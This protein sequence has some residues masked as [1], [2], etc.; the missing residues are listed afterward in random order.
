MILQKAMVHHSG[1]QLT[2]L[3]KRISLEAAQRPQPQRDRV[4]QSFHAELGEADP[5]NSVVGGLYCHDCILHHSDRRP[6]GGTDHHQGF[7]SR[8]EIDQ[9][10][11]F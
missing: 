3:P 10:L 8:P 7:G 1:I 9:Q 11:D 6:P 4:G 5:I 2:L